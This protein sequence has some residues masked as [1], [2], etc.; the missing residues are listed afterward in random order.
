[1]G[2]NVGAVPPVWESFSKSYIFLND[3]FPKVGWLKLCLFCAF[4]NP[5]FSSAVLIKLVTTVLA[6]KAELILSLLN[7]PKKLAQPFYRTDNNWA[8][9]SC[10]HHRWWK[11]STSALAMLVWWII[12]QADAANSSFARYNLGQLGSFSSCHWNYWQ[13][14]IQIVSFFS[15]FVRLFNVLKLI[16]ETSSFRDLDNLDLDDLTIPD[17]IKLPNNNNNSSCNNNKNLG[18]NNNNNVNKGY[19]VSD[20]NNSKS[21]IISN[22]KVVLLISLQNKFTF[23]SP[24]PLI[25]TF[26]CVGS[27]TWQEGRVKSS[28]QAMVWPS[29]AAMEVWERRTEKAALPVGWGSSSGGSRTC[30]A[31]TRICPTR[32]SPATLWCLSSWMSGTPSSHQRS[33]QGHYHD[34][35]NI[36]ASTLHLKTM[37]SDF[38][39]KLEMLFLYWRRHFSMIGSSIYLI[40]IGNDQKTR[41]V[42]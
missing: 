42:K 28:S 11:N 32:T 10:S 1:M 23:S 12:R 15:L 31:R 26:R 3:G 30:P 24:L 33:S 29:Q 7:T 25:N 18:N 14:K 27:A 4:K 41:C 39:D 9:F 16:L 8:D 19:A 38:M 37:N 34:Y 13:Q 6:T 40:L 17:V 21:S 35:Y 22:V 2:T 20:E 36:K 5:K